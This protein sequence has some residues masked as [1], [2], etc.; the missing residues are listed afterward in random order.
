MSNYPFNLKKSES[1][2]AQ[3]RSA[4]LLKEKICDI[5]SFG[6]DCMLSKK[7]SMPRILK[8][9]LSSYV[10]ISLS[11]DLSMLGLRLAVKQFKRQGST[12]QYSAPVALFDLKKF[13]IGI[14][15]C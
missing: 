12:V 1:I 7:G 15:T 9:Y 10:F 6:N 11:D 3:F 4:N 13:D 14:V 8:I 2:P 5:W